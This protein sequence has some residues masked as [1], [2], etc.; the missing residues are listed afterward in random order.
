M[1]LLAPEV[2]SWSDGGGVVRAALR[3]L[4]GPDHVAR[5][6]LGVLRKPEMDGVVWDVEWIN[7]EE[8]VLFRGPDGAVRGSVNVDIRDGLV[9]GLRAQLN[10][11]KLAGLGGAVRLTL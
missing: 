10:P 2:T 1:E 11:E 8:G 6:L 7:G 4:H 3:P 5:W 9:C